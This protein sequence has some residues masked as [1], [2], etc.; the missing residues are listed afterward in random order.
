MFV[1]ADRWRDYADLGW[2]NAPNLAES[3]VIFAVDFGPLGNAAVIEA[4]P[5]RRVYYFDRTQ[6]F[7]L[8]AGRG[9]E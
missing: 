7:P 3:N 6:P 5:D 8:V 9:D 1:H 2:L 4:F